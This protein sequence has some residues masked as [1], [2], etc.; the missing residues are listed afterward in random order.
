MRVG[1]IDVAVA[2]L[3]MC[4]K[5][6]LVAVAGLFLILVFVEFIGFFERF[7]IS[8]RLSPAKKLLTLG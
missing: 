2:G 3:L 6:E 7:E 8:E 1:L 5:V 4:L